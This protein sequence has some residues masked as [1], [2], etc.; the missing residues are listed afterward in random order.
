MS[1]DEFLDSLIFDAFSEVRES[2]AT[3]LDLYEAPYC[4]GLVMITQ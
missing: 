1:V 2:L 3:D 4:L